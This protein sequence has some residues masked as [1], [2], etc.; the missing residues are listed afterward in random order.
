MIYVLYIIYKANTY[1]KYLSMDDVF[2]YFSILAT[3]CIFTLQ[4]LLIFT[5]LAIF[6]S[7]HTIYNNIQ[8]CI[9]I[10][11]FVL[12]VLCVRTILPV[13]DLYYNFSQ[14][15]LLICF[16]ISIFLK[17]SQEATVDYKCFPIL[18]FEFF[19]KII[20]N[21]YKTFISFFHKNHLNNCFKKGSVCRKLSS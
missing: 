3:R 1:I 9:C 13:Q 8:S 18:C 10:Y 4:L 15:I 20:I 7:F 5:I 2:L 11:K 12:C 17:F 14:F 21:K 19:Y 16:M 6:M